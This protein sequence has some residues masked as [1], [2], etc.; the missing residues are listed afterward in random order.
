MRH[1]KDFFNEICSLRRQTTHSIGTFLTNK[2]VCPCLNSTNI[3]SQSN[4]GFFSL[5]DPYCDILK[6]ALNYESQ[7]F[8]S[9]F[10]FSTQ[11]WG[12]V[13]VLRILRFFRPD[14]LDRDQLWLKID[15]DGDNNRLWTN[16][17]FCFLCVFVNN[18]VPSTIFVPLI[19]H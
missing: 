16:S 1:L 13:W 14:L 9:I 8:Y 4:N 3:F 2:N 6:W 18:L 7:K 19:F 15:F 10:F 12:P 5:L 11:T 17:Y